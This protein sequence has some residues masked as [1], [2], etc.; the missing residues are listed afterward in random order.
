[1][2]IICFQQIPLHTATGKRDWIFSIP[3]SGDGRILL[4]PFHSNS[5]F[6]PAGR[7]RGRKLFFW[8]RKPFVRFPCQ[9]HKS[10]NGYARWP[11]W[12]A[13]APGSFNI[14]QS[15]L[16][17]LRVSAAYPNRRWLL[18]LLGKPEGLSVKKNSFRS[19]DTFTEER[20]TS[21]SELEGNTFRS[22][23][24]GKGCTKSLKC[25]PY[26]SMEG[27]SVKS[28]YIAHKYFCTTV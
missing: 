15:F 19:H 28:I 8:G 27:E 22:S 13:A 18:P 25:F 3:S 21:D 7:Y 23:P 9:R 20:K 16:R 2:G 26:G 6:F 5:V 12:A 14:K 4:I 24:G 1:M 17:Q 10:T 11:V